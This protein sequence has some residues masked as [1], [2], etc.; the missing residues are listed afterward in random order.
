VRTREPDVTG[1][2]GKVAAGAVDAGIVYATDIRAADGLLAV[3]IPAR[4]QPR[5]EYA[6]AATGDSAAAER[7]VSGLA[8]APALRD[9]GFGAP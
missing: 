7:F 9:A 1:V 6:A 2:I 5:I 4:L 8:T 3:A